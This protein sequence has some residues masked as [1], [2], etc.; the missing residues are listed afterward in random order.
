MI[1]VL[2]NGIFGRNLWYLRKKYSLSQIALAKLTHISINKLKHIERGY[3]R[4]VET[5]WFLRICS[6]FELTEEES[7][8]V[9]NE[10]YE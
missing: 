10:L 3:I 2:N 9:L 7:G 5:Q 8:N 1:I 4:K 6:I